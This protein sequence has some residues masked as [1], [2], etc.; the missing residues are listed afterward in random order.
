MHLVIEHRLEVLRRRLR[1]E[2]EARRVSKLA[3]RN[4]REYS[5]HEGACERASMCEAAQQIHSAHALVLRRLLRNFISTE[6][7]NS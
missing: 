6:N 7:P 4:W 3:A 2:L 1:E 5:A